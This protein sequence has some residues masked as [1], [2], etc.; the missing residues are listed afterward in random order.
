MLE[1]V[2]G[3]RRNPAAA[4]SLLDVLTALDL[5]GTLYIGYPILASLDEPIV[6]D[7]L[8]TCLEHGVV[9]FDFAD[10]PIDPASVR[11]RHDELFLA[12]EQQL[13]RVRELVVNRQ[14]SVQVTPLSFIPG[15]TLEQ[16]GEDLVATPG[17]LPEMLGT[18]KRISPDQLQ[19][20]NAAIQRVATIRP[21]TRRNSVTRP[22]SLGAKLRHIERQIAN[23]DQW[24]KVAA[25]ETPEGPQ[26]IRGLAGSGKTVVLALKAAYLHAL[27]PDWK[28]ALTFQT[29]SL[30]QQF[31]DLVRRFS[32][33]H[34]NDEPNWAQ[35]QILHSWGSRRFPGFYSTL[36]EASGQ[37]VRDFLYAKSLFGAERAFEG[38]CDELLAN[39]TGSGLG[40][41]YDAVL[42]DEAQDFPASYFQL[43]F[44]ATREPRRIIWAY[45]E[46]Q[47]LSQYSM[48]PPSE[49]FGTDTQGRPNVPDFVEARA[50]PRRDLILP[51]CYRNTPWALTTAH[52]VG[53]GVYRSRG[54]IQFFN[55]PELWQAVGYQ[56]RDG[57]LRPGSFVS[58]ER[59]EDAS[60]SYFRELLSPEEAITWD[61]VDDA[62]QQATIVASLIQNNLENDELQ[63]SDI[64]VIFAN[65]LRVQKDAVALM[66]AL[67]E[68]GIESHLAG[69]T[70][71]VDQ[72]FVENSVAISGIYRAKGNEA[73]MVYVL[74]SEYCYEGLGLIRRRN[75]LFTAMTRSR[76]W[77]R[78][79][80]CGIG[81]RHLAEEMD[82]VRQHGYRLEFQIPTGAELE[83]LRRIHRDRTQSEEERVKKAQSGL[84]ELVTM[85][86]AGT[87]EREN[88]PAELLEKL[89]TLLRGTR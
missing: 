38:I 14:L 31:K 61:I 7:A 15:E 64:L 84:E 82:N 46:L 18:L 30:Y 13:K 66:A 36:A 88:I 5:H 2:I 55:E 80:G 67:N 49:L 40:P 9:V 6:I 10:L 27:H 53:F 70:S 57:E 86:E 8:L 71:S 23:L 68:R 85:V 37:P 22:D 72:L 35:L 76:A 28:I 44:L 87:L 26:R 42:I 73:A 11:P 65:P 24:Q 74:N 54:L 16:H 59:R 3:D 29:R 19:L 34:L 89:E 56:V 52:A 39:L 47:N 1:T 60:P 63:P 45:D 33:E 51:V 75:I 79:F 78:I 32:F 77:V 43:A 12:L 21:A 17:S 25:I 50:E 81:M 62:A 83:H 41:L 58:L 48:A 20:I 4:Q 69:I